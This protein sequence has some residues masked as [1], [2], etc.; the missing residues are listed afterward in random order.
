MFCFFLSAGKGRPWPN[1]GPTRLAQGQADPRPGPLKLARPWGGQVKGQQKWAGPGP[2][3][4][5]DSV[6]PYWL[7]TGSEVEKDRCEPVIKGPVRLS[8][9]PKDHVVGSDSGSSPKWK[10]TGPD[11]T[12]KHYIMEYQ[13]SYELYSAIWSFY[14]VKTISST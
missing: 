13:H 10:K 5:L 1:P 2:A 8:W 3:R 14:I 9:C 7:T 11:R 6:D 12:F 4:P